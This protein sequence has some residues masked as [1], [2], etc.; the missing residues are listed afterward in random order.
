MAKART[1]PPS[2]GDSVE[3]ATGI[4]SC[5]SGE[6]SCC[7]LLGTYQWREIRPFALSCAV[8]LSHRQARGRKGTGTWARQWQSVFVSPNGHVK[9]RSNR[10][11]ATS[12]LLATCTCSGVFCTWSAMSSGGLRE[13]VLSNFVATKVLTRT[14][15]PYCIEFGSDYTYPY[16]VVSPARIEELSRRE[17]CH[18]SRSTRRSADPH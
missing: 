7:H 12:C 6:L 8:S 4:T 11:C 17:P 13:L 10:S 9:L 2:Q 1:A 18:P 15:N 14:R 5:I 3:P 16:F